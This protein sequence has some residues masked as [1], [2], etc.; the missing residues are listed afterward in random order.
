MWGCRT[1]IGYGSL[2]AGSHDV[3]G[4]PLKPDDLQQVK[5]KFGFDGSKKFFVPEDVRVC[6]SHATRADKYIKHKPTPP[7]PQVQQ[8]FSQAIA[9][10]AQAEADWATLLARYTVAYPAEAAELARRAA[11]QLPANW[12]ALLP[13]WTPSDKPLA[14]RQTSEIVLNALAPALPELVGG[15]AD[16]TPSNLTCRKPVHIYTCEN[17]C[18][19]GIEIVGCALQG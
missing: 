18:D 8:H 10:G 9:R 17:A 16:L 15:S 2:K 12:M 4:A 14:T 5:A 11:G 1:T 13:T 6:I 19:C 7:P 3:H